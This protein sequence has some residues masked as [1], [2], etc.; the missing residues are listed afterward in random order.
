VSKRPKSTLE[1]EKKSLGET[2]EKVLKR[3]REAFDKELKKQ[4]DQILKKRKELFETLERPINNEKEIPI[5]NFE[6]D[7]KGPIIRY[8]LPSPSS[9]E[10]KN[11]VELNDI[12]KDDFNEEN[13]VTVKDLTQILS[14]NRD[15]IREFLSNLTKEELEEELF[16]LGIEAIEPP[17]SAELAEIN[18]QIASREATI[19]NLRQQLA[20]IPKGWLWVINFF[21]I[22][23]LTNR[24]RVNETILK[25]LRA[26][27][28]QIEA[29]YTEEFPVKPVIPEDVDTFRVRYELFKYYLEIAM[30]FKNLIPA[31]YKSMGNH[32]KIKFI[33]IE[34]LKPRL[35]FVETLKLTN[36]PGDYGAGT[37]IKTFSLLPR[38]IT[39]ISVKTWKKTETTTKEASSI[40]DSYTE[41]KADEFER[42]VQSENSRFSKIDKSSSYNVKASA[43]ARWGWGSASV[44]GGKEGSTKSS[45]ESSVKNVMNAT[46]KHAQTASA[47]RE[48][49]IDTEHEKREE[50]GVET[51]TMRTIRNLNVSRTL[52]FTFRQMNQ[53]FHSI[54][55]LTDLKMGFYN[56][57]PGSLREYPLSD[58]WH[59]VNKYMKTPEVFIDTLKSIIMKEYGTVTDDQGNEIYG[60][61]DHYGNARALV[62]EVTFQGETLPYL[63]V[64]PPYD[65][66]G[67]PHGQQNYIM[68]PEIRDE[69]D[70]IIQE[71]DM[72]YV[73]G[74]ILGNQIVTMKTEGV[75][76]E[77]LMGKV[78]ALDDYSYLY[79]IEKIRKKRAENERIL[80]GLNLVKELLNMKKFDDAV[81]AYKETFGV[82]PGIEVLKNLFSFKVETVA[83]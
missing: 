17:V 33:S 9:Y 19:N 4:E 56:G 47:K 63:R 73:E 53:Q 51:A 25:V 69:N 35:L 2:Q 48:V 36:F 57:Y 8:D 58:I 67:K 59:F 16:G 82:E 81:L 83:E 54:L 75:I 32:L 79:R 12:G 23:D 5:I 40:L 80:E 6:S 50:T 30:R 52:N 20:D 29:A 44:S 42:G 49:N 14:K 10:G 34:E 61:I 26:K 37:T 38:E 15:V 64:I 68:R 1:K 74:I 27:K 46:A 72:R 70:Q 3:L 77:A 55:H 45:R 21:K 22:V 18:K 76:V 13:A 62:E 66:E 24:I 60:V 28:V 71:E 11:I 78:N 39:E 41:E 7:A 65:K 43:S 31:F